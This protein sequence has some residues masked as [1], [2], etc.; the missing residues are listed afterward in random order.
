MTK[1]KDLM[2]KS[3]PAKENQ[4]PKSK[5]DKDDDKSSKKTVGS[6]LDRFRSAGK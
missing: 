2:L 6:F 4:K 1:V 3:K 5:A